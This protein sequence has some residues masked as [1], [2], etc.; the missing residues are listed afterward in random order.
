MIRVN[1]IKLKPGYKKDDIIEAIARQI[2]S[3]T[4]DIEGFSEVKL[5]VDARNKKDVF[6]VAV[7]DVE[8]K[9]ERKY[10]GR[11]HVARCEKYEYEYP[12]PWRSEHRPVVVGAGPAGLFAALILAYRGAKPVV[13][14][15]GERVENRINTVE[16][17]WRTGVLNPESN[18]QF[19]EGG[20]GTFSDGKLNTG[21]RDVRQRKVLE[22]MTEA[23]APREILYK[24][25]PHVG[26]DE[27]RNMV[28]NIREKII[29][30]GGEFI[31]NCRM[32]DI[33]IEDNAVKGIKTTLG[34]FETKTL[35]LAIG[36]SA[37]DTFR[38]IQRLNI[39]MERKP[40]SVGVRIEHLRSDIDYAQYGDFAPLM[41]AADY[42]CNIKDRNGR[43]V[44][45]FCMCPGGCVVA[46][47][48]EHEGV[49]TN[50][51]SNFARDGK[52]SNSALLVSVYPEDFEG[53]DPL[54]GMYFQRKLEKGAFYQAGAD[55]KAPCQRVGDFYNG[56]KSVQFGRV[57][58]T[59]EP[60]VT[61][62]D[63]NRLL[64]LHIADGLKDAIEGFARKIKCFND[65]DA[66]LT[67]I[68]TRSSSP[69]R[70]IRND[71]FSSYIK[72]L[73][74]CGE[75]AGYAGGIMSAAV[76]GIKIGEVCE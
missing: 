24:A 23:G 41:D 42:K 57:S 5:S 3:P 26:T 31:F 50:G 55:Y 13:I 15:R 53:S 49:V 4:G 21:T 37:R 64:P 69:V 18:V 22:E 1:N 28:K 70:I 62:S 6:Y 16:K 45:T 73:Y 67:G 14:E 25:K 20:A 39:P 66:V 19:G 71:G 17:F 68:E 58:P 11:E 43:G 7:F 63:L 30:M 10:Y 65:P 40:F 38:L 27:L 32:D 54:S 56:K 60:G 51:M 34:D 46:S 76:D 35:I 47:A 8:I 2:K 75:G 29:S 48:S 52:N 36:H 44:Y 59:Y 72:G 61:P 33:I 74:P 12:L 9:D